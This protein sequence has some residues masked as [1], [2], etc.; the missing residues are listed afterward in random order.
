[1]LDVAS[2]EVKQDL[3][4]S[5]ELCSDHCWLKLKFKSIKVKVKFFHGFEARKI[6]VTN[7]VGFTDLDFITFVSEF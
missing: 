1:M 2:N 3:W 5:H 7:F 6:S 4:S